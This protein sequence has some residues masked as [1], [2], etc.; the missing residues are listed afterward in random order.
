MNIIQMKLCEINP[1]VRYSHCF[2]VEPGTSF[3]KVVPYD[4][5]LLYIADG[6]GFIKIGGKEFAASEGCV[7]LWRPGMEYSYLPNIGRPFTIY[8][9]NFDFSMRHSSIDYPV[10][11]DRADDFDCKKIIEIVNIIDFPASNSVFCM[12]HMQAG[13]HISLAMNKEYRT[14]RTFFDGKLRGLL[15]MLLTGIIRSTAISEAAGS[16][17]M[18]KTDAVIAYIQE[19]YDKELT[20]SDIS[21]EFNFH[22]AYISRMMNRCTGMSLHRYLIRYRISIALNLLQTTSFS[23]SEIAEKAGFS[24]FNYFSRCFKRYLGQSPR[25]FSAK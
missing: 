14:R 3:V 16:H 6:N 20:N 18:A 7:F 12:K 8:G 13:K 11:L 25:N 19:H 2:P 21:R 23:V 10:I 4:Y 5:R 22:P 17:A 9:I 15:L 1:Y 24:D